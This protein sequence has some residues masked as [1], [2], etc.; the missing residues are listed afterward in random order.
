MTKWAD[1]S[2][3]RLTTSQMPVLRTLDPVPASKMTGAVKPN[4]LYELGD[5]ASCLSRVVR[6]SL[7]SDQRHGC[8]GGLSNIQ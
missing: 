7:V 8:Q 2:G 6:R 4:Y 5:V 3:V 1:R